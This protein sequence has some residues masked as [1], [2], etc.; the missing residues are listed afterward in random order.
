MRCIRQGG[1]S[2]EVGWGV[3]FFSGTGCKVFIMSSYPCL[4]SF[5]LARSRYVG[6]V[7]GEELVFGGIVVGGGSAIAKDMMVIESERLTSMQA[8]PTGR[9]GGAKRKAC[10]RC[11]G[12]PSQ[13]RFASKVTDCADTHPLVEKHSVL[14]RAHER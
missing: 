14:S 4:T 6:N 7:R 3:F 10:Y 12:C 13:Q 8:S 5:I 9:A 1:R 11:L 2:D